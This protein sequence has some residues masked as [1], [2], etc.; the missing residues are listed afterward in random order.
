MS[1]AESEAPACPPR[2]DA[3][4]QLA[5]QLIARMQADY[6]KAAPF[7]EGSE[8]SSAYSARTHLSEMAGIHAR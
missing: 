8:A 4:E 7:L 2:I 6:K 1:A 3:N 5:L